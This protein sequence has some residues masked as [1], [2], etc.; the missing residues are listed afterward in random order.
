[1]PIEI[2]ELNIRVNVSENA[3]G[4]SGGSTSP[5]SAT[6][7]SG[8]GMPDQAALVQEAVEQVLEILR[9]KTER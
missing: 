9:T 3:G 5:G 8:S 6:P 7:Q 4:N 2:R 1:M